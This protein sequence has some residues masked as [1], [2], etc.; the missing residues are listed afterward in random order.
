MSKRVFGI[1][2]SLVMVMMVF[3]GNTA[4]AADGDKPVDIIGVSANGGQQIRIGDEFELLLRLKNNTDG[5]IKDVTVTFSGSASVRPIDSILIKQF[6]SEV[7][8]GQTTEQVF[9]F[10]HTGETGTE[11]PMVIT[12]K[13]KNGNTRTE[14]D[15][16]WI[17]NLSQDINSG[18]G[19]SGVKFKPIL[20]I[21]DK[22]IPE[23][24]AGNK[25]TIP[26][27]VTNVS[28]YEAKRITIKPQLPENVFVI[29][30]MI[31]DS[32]IESIPAKKAENVVL[33]FEIDKNA[34]ANTYKVPLKITYTNVYGNQDITEEVEIYI[35]VLN[36][37][38][39]PQLVVKEATPSLQKIPEEQDFT[40]TFNAWNMGTLDAKNVTVELKADNE[41]FY[42]LDNLTKRYFSE[43]KGQQ[44]EELT[45]SLRTRKDLVSGTYEITV[46]LM[47]DGATAVEYP[48]YVN[49]LGTK[50]D[51]KEKEEEKDDINIITENVNAPEGV[52]LVEQPF[53]ASFN[54][55]NT[56][57]TVAKT[58]KVTIDGGDKILPRSLNVLTL[59]DINPGESVPVAFSFIAT[60][61]CDSRTYP[62]KASVEYTNNE[63]TFHKDQ[64]IGVSIQNP[65]K[66]KEKEK[67]EEEEDTTRNTVPKIIISEYSTDPVMVSAGE[68][69]TLRMKF[70]NT[71]KVKAVENMKITLVVNEGSE[72]TGSVFSPVQSSNTF[73]IAHLN[74]GETAVKEMMMYT[75]PD[76]QA[77]TYVVKASFEYEYEEKDQLKTNTMDDLF[78]IPVVQPAKLETSDVFVSEPAIIGEPVYLSSEFYNMGKVTLS[79]LMVK[80]EGD[81]DT[82]ESNYFVGNFEMGM[83]DFYEAPITPLM[84]GETKGLLVFTFE[85]SAGKEHR[86]EKEFTVNAMESSPAMNPG[87]PMDPNFPMDPG[88]MDPGME[89]MKGPRLPI[90][91]I[92]I[93]AGV[94]ILFIVFMIIRKRRKKRKE[95]MLDENI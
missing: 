59:T 36:N 22:A 1:L 9:H 27:T 31:V 68:N 19:D 84:P 38:L 94:V 34:V 16:V 23:G 49:V 50:D 62:I 12:Y 89:G 14:N 54:V 42:V 92:A 57:T 18:T 87:F 93:G 70:L 79:N 2:I 41:R 37:N 40:V 71:N 51:D 26:L 86:I 75:I 73:Y 20:V 10:F 8:S 45:Y 80:V 74:P 39:P 85:D 66:D 30:Q 46:S 78:G 13:D 7:G 64:Y 53:T 25:I 24:S 52:V 28:S 58:V 63:E 76:A 56:G 35:K 11:L 61:D 21:G 81:F 17:S 32:K 67:E 95:M 83:S 65:E 91:P 43:L 88:M 15:S 47:H 82:K 33:Q 69:F 3:A 6:A 60:K 77:K 55:K 90:I 4:Y 44:S 72:K 5:I 29:N 48:M